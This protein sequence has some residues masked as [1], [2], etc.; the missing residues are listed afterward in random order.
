M[1]VTKRKGV[2]EIN[3]NPIPKAGDSLCVAAPSVAA[4]LTSRELGCS[5]L[6]LS[7][8][9]HQ[10]QVAIAGFLV[11]HHWEGVI[12]TWCDTETAAFTEPIKGVPLDLLQGKRL[13]LFL[14]YMASKI[15]H[16]TRSSE[17]PASLHQRVR[18]P[19]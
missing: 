9:F 11:V 5:V 6:F 4:P 17:V 16:V 13:Q 7:D 10:L 14:K 19:I 8:P 2:P 3:T 18:A 1:L 15:D 12:S